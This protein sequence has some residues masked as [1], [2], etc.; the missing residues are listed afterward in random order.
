MSV[1]GWV[2]VITN[3]AMPSLVKV[4]FSTKDP[5]TRA[6]SFDQAGLPYS[7]E[8]A[9]DVIVENPYLVEQKIHA[10]LNE[11]KE[12]KEWFKC[13][14]AHAVDTIRRITEGSRIVE[15]EHKTI[16]SSAPSEKYYKGYAAEFANQCST[17]HKRGNDYNKSELISELKK[18][19]WSI[20]SD[21]IKM[22]LTRSGWQPVIAYTPDDLNRILL[23]TQ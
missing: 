11:T 19:G 8:V 6:Q 15:Q 12:N 4:G 18:R 2:Y 3:K 1:R 20:E 22:L 23:N 14:V 5:I 10:A 13:S 21:G 7:Y 9:Y 17:T 16:G